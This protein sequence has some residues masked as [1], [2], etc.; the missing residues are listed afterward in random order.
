MQV[1]E[2]APLF[3]VQALSGTIPTVPSVARHFVDCSYPRQLSPVPPTPASLFP[4]PCLCHTWVSSSLLITI[5]ESTQLLTQTVCAC[6]SPLV[7]F[8]RIDFSCGD[9]TMAASMAVR[10][11]FLLVVLATASQTY[12]QVMHV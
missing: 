9:C 6:A 5:P 3:P 4:F 12:A 7:F 10:S 11:L 8:N 1:S 2:V